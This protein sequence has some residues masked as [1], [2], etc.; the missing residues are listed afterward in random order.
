MSQNVFYLGV[1]KLSEEFKGIVIGSYSYNTDIDLG[2][3]R[4]VIEQPSLD[5]SPGKHYSFQV[6]EVT[7]HL[8]QG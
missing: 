7:W 1:G 6:G 3:V 8:I 2:G 5:M 4:K